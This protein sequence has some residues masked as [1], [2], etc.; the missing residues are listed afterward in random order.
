MEVTDQITEEE[1]DDGYYYVADNE[2]ITV[3]QFILLSLATFGL[4]DLWWT[5]KAWRFF[6]QKEGLDIQPAMRAVLA[7]IYLIPLFNKIQRFAGTKDYPERYFSILLFLG[8]LLVNLLSYLPTPFSLLSL[9][10]FMLFIPPFKALNFAKEY[11]ADLQVSWQ[12]RFNGR[13]KALLVFGGILWL[14]ILIGL[15][16]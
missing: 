15:L 1:P 10:S 2:I 5:Y 4:Y 11:S 8:I 14:L 16:A 6:Q 12:E 13:Q 3:N 9:L 7:I